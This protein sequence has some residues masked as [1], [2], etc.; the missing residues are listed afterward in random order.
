MYARPATGVGRGALGFDGEG[1]VVCRPRATIVDGDG[2]G[3]GLNPA[4]RLA[5]RDRLGADGQVGQRLVAEERSVTGALVERSSR[6]CVRT[7][8]P[9]W[10]VRRRVA[11]WLVVT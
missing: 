11:A 4:I 5:V 2:Q 3:R 10:Q 7:P 8:L 9:D 6:Q 1:Q